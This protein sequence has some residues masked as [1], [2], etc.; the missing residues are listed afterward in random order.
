[1]K[2]VPKLEGTHSAAVL[3]EVVVLAGVGL[4]VMLSADY[5]FLLKV[6]SVT[7]ATYM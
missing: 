4:S 6:W 5:C 3:V 2:L 7:V 1:M